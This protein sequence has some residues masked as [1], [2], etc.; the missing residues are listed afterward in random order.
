MK[1][2]AIIIS[3][4]TLSIPEARKRM[5]QLANGFAVGAFE[6]EKHTKH[7]KEFEEIREKLRKING[8]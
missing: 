6:K 7:W 5:N 1:P 4:K 3:G 8:Y 2:K